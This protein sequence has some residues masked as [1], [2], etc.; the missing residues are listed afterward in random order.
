MLTLALLARFLRGSEKLEVTFQYND[1]NTLRLVIKTTLAA[2]PKNADEDLKRI[3][4][5][6]ARPLILD[7]S[8]DELDSQLAAFLAGA[9]EIRTQAVVSYESLLA[10][11]KDT[12]ADAG[13]TAGKKAAKPAK[14]TPAPAKPAVVDAAEEE[15][16]EETPDEPAPTP[17][18]AAPA[19]VSGTVDLFKA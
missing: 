5:K 19:T 13:R 6:L 15:E 11:L 4:A 10:E 12:A 1:N 16:E 18:A 7:S 14:T 3:R 8:I 2:E 17:A 9:A